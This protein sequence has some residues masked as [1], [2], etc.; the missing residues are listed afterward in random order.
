LA[1]ARNV[2]VNYNEKKTKKFL[3]EGQPQFSLIYGYRH[4]ASMAAGPASKC[5][6][7]NHMKKNS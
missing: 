5:T 1:A 3:R 2:Q 6:L 7:T 4:L